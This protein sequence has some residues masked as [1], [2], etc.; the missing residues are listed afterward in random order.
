MPL[1]PKFVAKK[2][3]FYLLMVVVLLCFVAMVI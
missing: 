3:P 2:I 1:G